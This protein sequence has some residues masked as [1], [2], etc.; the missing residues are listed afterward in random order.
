MIAEI[1]SVGTELLMGQ[2]VNT[3]AQ[4]IA[5]NLAPLGY[6]CYYQVTV[7]DN[8]QR[9]TD[10]V[11]TALSRSDLVI[12]TG[13]LGPT[14]DDLTK[15]TVAE[16]L[17]LT[18]VPI[19]EQVEVLKRQFRNAGWNMT[20]NNLK[21]ASFPESAIILK[22]DHG[23]A[24]GCIMEADG[25]AA[26]LLPGPPN[27]LF[28]MFDHYVLPYLEKRGNCHL[29]SRILKITGVGESR[30]TY[31][32]RDLI[33]SQTNPTIA[34]YAKTGEVELRL[35]AKC[36]TDEEGE[37]LIAPVMRTILDHFGPSVYSVDGETLEEVCAKAM[38]AC[39]KTLSVYE[40]GSGGLVC[41]A[42]TSVPGHERFLKEGRVV[43]GCD[44]SISSA[45]PFGP[46]YALALAHAARKASGTDLGLSVGPVR[47]TENPGSRMTG[48]A[49]V[50]IADADSEKTVVLNMMG[51]PE[52]L[53]R[54]CMLKAM[55]LLRRKCLNQPLD[56]DII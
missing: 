19:P 16:A 10:A 15:E 52:R 23:T 31:E 38:T 22:N 44:T 43:C 21:Q 29:H 56:I 5:K 37:A 40:T 51:S 45:D 2:I 41:A 26:I 13:G 35:T 24:P 12:F 14:D 30:L 36:A 42:L 27:E 47:T 34:P 50:A 9:L 53:R 8:A 3:D 49:Y 6:I 55:D 18:C 7:G 17:G 39:S 33:S 46:E 1:V 54:I 28:P 48:T 25:K 32:I 4:H 20:P 11:R